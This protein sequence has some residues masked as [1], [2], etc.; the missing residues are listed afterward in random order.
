MESFRTTLA[1]VVGLTLVVTGI[2]DECPRIGAIAIGLLVMGVFS[3]P[4]ALTLIRGTNGS[5]K[6][7]DNE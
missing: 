3:V 5:S 7:T 2:L 1:F 4:E 6:G